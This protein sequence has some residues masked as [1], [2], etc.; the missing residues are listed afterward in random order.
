MDHTHCF[1]DEQLY[2]QFAE[3][4][5]GKTGSVS[6]A[7]NE[8]MKIWLQLGSLGARL[9]RRGL[10]GRRRTSCAPRSPGG[11]L[12]RE[13]T[14]RGASWEAFETCEQKLLTL[15]PRPPLHCFV[16]RA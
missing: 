7:L 11:R 14:L 15:E 3:Q 12:V 9:E 1:N 16:F 2:E 5:K 10:R 13:R 4:A 8:A 6:K